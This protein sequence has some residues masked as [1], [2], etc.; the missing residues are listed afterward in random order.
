RSHVV[1]LNGDPARITAEFTPPQ[2]DPE[3]VGTDDDAIAVVGISGRYPMARDLD[4]FW[5]NLRDGRDCISTVP[6]DRW[7]HAAIYSEDRH[8][9]GRSYGK[10]GGFISGV[11]EFDAGFFHISPN[12]AAVLDPQE[13][14]FLQEAWHAFEEAGHAPSAWRGRSV[15]VFAGVMY[16]QY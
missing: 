13:R 11:D 7:D 6:A 1:V 8:T 12:E 10:W 15:G 2:A 3:P 16:N 5:A 14:L 9:P 4:E